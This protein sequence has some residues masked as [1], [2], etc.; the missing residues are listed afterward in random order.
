MGVVLLNRAPTDL[1]TAT[2]SP[3]LPTS[4]SSPVAQGEPALT[5]SATPVASAASSAGS[6]AAPGE[7][8]LPTST[9]APPAVLVGAGDI[10][11][12]FSEGDEAT[13]ALLDRIEG[14]VF[15]LGDNA[16][17]SGTDA[18][19][20]TCYEPTWGRHRARTFPT[21]GNHD[22]ETFGAAGYFTYF[23]PAAGNFGEGWYSYD[24]G[25]WHVVVLNSICAAV[26]GCHAGSPQEAWL[27]ADLAANPTRCTLAYWHNP[28]FS[29]A[30]HGSDPA[31]DAFWRALHEAGAEL[32]LNGHD[33]VYE[34]FAPQSPDALPDPDAGIRQFTVGTGG[35]S[36][37]DIGPP[38]ANSELQGVGSFGL[39]RLELYESGYEW[40][41]VP[42]TEGGF[43]DSGTG[44]CH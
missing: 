33:H 13:A 9:L 5:E 28:R 31:Y 38:I 1:G 8:P 20:A 17:P 11:S 21:P 30:M 3:S 41:F 35:E 12:C 16:Y 32:V 10:A 44:T 43:T 7:T 42:A 29:S 40:E 19:F 24:V 36:V 39:L 22:Y 23:G 25:S 37:R 14:T 2:A 6:S 15:T 18:Q 26:G 27:R 34:R 4:T